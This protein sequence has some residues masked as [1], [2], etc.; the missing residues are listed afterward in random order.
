MLVIRSRQQQQQRNGIN[1][2]DD[3]NPAGNGDGGIGGVP[4]PVNNA[5]NINN[6]TINNNNNNNNIRFW[7]NPAFYSTVWFFF[8]QFVILFATMSNPILHII[9]DMILRMAG[10][11]NFG[12]FGGPL[13]NHRWG[14][15][16]LNRL[17]MNLLAGEDGDELLNL[18]N[19]NDTEPGNWSM[20]YSPSSENDVD[21]DDEDGDEVPNV[22]A[23]PN[24]PSPSIESL[25]TPSISD[26]SPS[27]ADQIS[28][29]EIS[30]DFEMVTNSMESF[31]TIDGDGEV[32]GT[33]KAE[34]ISDAIQAEHTANDMNIIPNNDSSRIQGSSSAFTSHHNFN[35]I[36]N[37]SNPIDS[38]LPTTS[39]SHRTTSEATTPA[40]PMTMATT[41]SR[42][43]LAGG[44]S[45]ENDEKSHKPRINSIVNCNVRDSVTGSNCS[46]T[47]NNQPVKLATAAKQ[48]DCDD[49]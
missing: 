47:L 37:S 31:T 19:E 18:L 12:L 2:N 17:P 24:E 42:D 33:Y 21:N 27:T 30:K 43:C 13:F 40:R 35:T 44:T 7:R 26:S 20:I 41:S 3:A 45:I 22:A 23:M 29:S 14:H 16:N 32:A 49:K 34:K 1:Q 25:Q 4:N 10:F 8:E 36:P 15:R 46:D 39:E 11:N 48:F 5:R 38:I 28:D 6:N 9:E